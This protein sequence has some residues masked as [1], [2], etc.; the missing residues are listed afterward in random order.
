MHNF[1]QLKVWNNARE[2]VKRVYEISLQFP[3]VERFGLTSQIRRAAISIPSNIAEGCGRNTDKD[4]AKFMGYAL[5]SAYEVETELILAYDLAFIDKRTVKE[6]VQEIQV[7][8]KNA[9]TAS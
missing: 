5:A 8:P 3:D 6:V 1:R 2:L 9:S 7:L 4:M